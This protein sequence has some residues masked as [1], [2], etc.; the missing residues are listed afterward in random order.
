MKTAQNQIGSL[1]K[2][3]SQLETKNQRLTR[4][5]PAWPNDDNQIQSNSDTYLGPV[6]PKEI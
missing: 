5:N 4:I 2:G 1:E 3:I 6:H